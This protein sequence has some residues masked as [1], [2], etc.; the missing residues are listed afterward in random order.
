MYCTGI[1]L[2]SGLL[3]GSQIPGACTV[4]FLCSKKYMENKNLSQTEQ[5]FGEN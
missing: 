4:I 1:A 3:F 2:I 5:M